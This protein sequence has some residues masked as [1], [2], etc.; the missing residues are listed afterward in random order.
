MNNKKSIIALSILAIVLVLGVG[1]AI[2]STIELTF[3]GTVTVGESPLN[4]TIS[5]TQ[6]T[7]NETAKIVHSW[8]NPSDISDTFTISEMSL[9]ETVT[10]TYTIKNNETDVV[11]TLSE[12]GSLTNSNTEYFEVTKINN[13]S[14]LE[15]GET[16]TITITVKLK[17]TPV[18]EENG[19]TTI[20]YKVKASP[21]GNTGSDSGQHS[22]GSIT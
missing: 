22:G 18:T 11:A 3:G 7:S 13:L 21:K 17:K 19:R 15:P 12:S 16:G 2:V 10:I 6:S 1:Y 20:S 4:V 9:N 14:E 8:K 5:N